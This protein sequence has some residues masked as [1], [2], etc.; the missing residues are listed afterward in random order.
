[1][2]AAMVYGV[3]I[4]SIGTWP[5]VEI[6]AEE[7][8][9]IKTA[10]S[11]LLAV[12]DIEDRFELLAEN[13]AEYESTILAVAQRRMVRRH[14]DGWTAAMDDLLLMNRR[15]ANVLMAGRMYEDQAKHA[16]SGVY[17]S[18]SNTFT[19][20]CAAF[21]EAYDES[22]G[23]RAMSAL[24]NYSQHQ[25]LP[26]GGFHYQSERTSRDGQDLICFGVRP[27]LNIAA[28]RAAEFK[29]SVLAELESHEGHHN[30]TAFVRA[31]VGG[32]GH[33]HEC[34]R[35]LTRA[36][37]SECRRTINDV[38]SIGRTRIGQTLGLA[39]VA[40]DE[41][42]NHPEVLEIFEDMLQRLDAL[43]ARYADLGYLKNWFVTG[44]A[45]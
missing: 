4:A 30:V 6:S 13:Y 21:S 28:L 7:F 26:I 14:D 27:Q 9:R 18:T 5:F 24:R 33:A 43:Q 29:R 19:R 44:E 35:E 42:G 16:V 36:D 25:G 12:L 40:R 22:L 32:I 38:L 20:L 39:I 45:V 23:Y 11:R 10:R 17:G 15:L 37:V 3:T 41:E 31:F 1:M 8:E 34:I 2:E